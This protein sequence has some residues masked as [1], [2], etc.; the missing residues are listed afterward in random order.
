MGCKYI[1]PTAFTERSA[2]ESIS[3][4]KIRKKVYKLIYFKC[5]D[6]RTFP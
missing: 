1:K 6:F 5:V 2:N 3:L 4:D